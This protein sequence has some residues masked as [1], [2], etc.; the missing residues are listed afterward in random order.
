M[1]KLYVHPLPVRIWH[2]INALSFIVLILSGIQIRYI[3]VVDVLPFRA[4]VNVHNFVGFLLIAN[5]FLWFGFYLFSDK[6][7]VYLPELSPAKHFKASFRQAMY[8]GYGIFRGHPNP[9]RVSVYHKFNAMQSMA[10]QIIMLLLLP[11][12]CVTGLLL[13][14]VER[15]RTA[16][17][18][19]GGVRVVDTVHVLIFIFA[20]GYI[21]IHPYLATL[22][23]TPLAHIK[24]MISGYEEIHDDG[25]KQAPEKQGQKQAA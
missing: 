18:L 6:I 25:G 4:A 3:G 7:K 2:W 13:W 14:D 24:A 22:G 15:F 11:L 9:H 19:F 17:E 1:Q 21:L 8:Y 10:Y 16:V 20:V 5:F 12:Q 23:H